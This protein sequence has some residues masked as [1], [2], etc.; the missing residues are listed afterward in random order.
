[1]EP[2]KVAERNIEPIITQERSIS[3]NIKILSG[4]LT[5]RLEATIIMAKMTWVSAM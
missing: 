1:M 2:P 3:I 4:K 5:G